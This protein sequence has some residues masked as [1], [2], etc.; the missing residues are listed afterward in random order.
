MNTTNEDK[1]KGQLFERLVDM[2]EEGHELN[3]EE[4]NLLASDKEAAEGFRQLAALRNVIA[5]PQPQKKSYS[6]HPERETADVGCNEANEVSRIAVMRHF[7]LWPCVVIAAA[8]LALAVITFPHFTSPGS[9]NH[10]LIAYEQ[11]PKPD[12]IF[13]KTNQTHPV[14]LTKV[15]RTSGAQLTKNKGQ[16]VLDYQALEQQ[17]FSVS[18]AIH[19]DTIE[20]PHGKDFKLVLADGTEVWLYADSRLIYPS[21]FVGRERRVY[22]EGEAYFLVTKNPERP[23]VIGTERMEARVLGTELNVSCRK[24]ADSPWYVALVTGKVEV[25]NRNNSSLLEPGQGVT[26]TDDGGML[27]CLVLE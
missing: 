25:Q 1:D 23:F 21:Q 13:L 20:I 10:E 12:G 22:L 6:N 17:G 2:I 3:D 8:V 5:T 19:S 7:R 9:V 15:K 14:D 26:I 18:N 24:D 27:V 4:M 16:L 11:M